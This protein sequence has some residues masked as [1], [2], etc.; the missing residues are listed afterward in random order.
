MIRARSGKLTFRRLFPRAM[1]VLLTLVAVGLLGFYGAAS[2]ARSTG[3]S[4]PYRHLP[5]FLNLAPK[6]VRER[7]DLAMRSAAGPEGPAAARA[8]AELVRLGGAALPYV[9][10]RLDTL[11][12]GARGRVAMAL[13]PVALRM[14]VAS[15]DDVATPERALLFF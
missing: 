7:A 12:P 5:V 13:G 1:R 14:R 11:E 9:L 6:D 4:W 8:R 10:P 15:A 2:A 3:S